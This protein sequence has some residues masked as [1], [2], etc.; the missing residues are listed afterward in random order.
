[1]R[2]LITL[3]KLI[4]WLT[5]LTAITLGVLVPG[6]WLYTAANLPNSI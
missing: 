2:A 3:F 1:M 6:T 5:L 4:L